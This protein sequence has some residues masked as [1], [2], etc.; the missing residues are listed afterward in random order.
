GAGRD[1]TLS[2]A[3]MIQR[4]CNQAADG[5]VMHEYQAREFY[6]AYCNFRETDESRFLDEIR[7]MIDECPYD[8]IVGNGYAAVLPQFAERW[9]SA[10]L[11]HLRRADRVAAIASLKTNCELFPRAYGYYST[12]PQATVKRMAAFHF[13]EMSRSRWDALSLD[14]K[15]AW[16]Y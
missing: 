7:S 1:G 2:V 8:C 13:G 12:S 9:S 5:R 10:T 16:Y 3:D 15:F 11:I 6:Q 4:L 14:E